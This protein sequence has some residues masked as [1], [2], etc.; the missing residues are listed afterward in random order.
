MTIELSKNAREDAISSLE[1]YFRENMDEPI[2]NMV[3]GALLDFFL[4]E[5][6]PSIYNKAITDAQQN[7]Q[8]RILELDM[9]V[10]EDEFQYWSRRQS[11]GKTRK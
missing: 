9:E 8:A 7:L 1:R 2:G 10:N 5:I 11:R 3:A 6:G 4:E